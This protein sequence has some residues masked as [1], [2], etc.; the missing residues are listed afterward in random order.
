VYAAGLRGEKVVWW[1]DEGIQSILVSF[2]GSGRG[3]SEMPREV[4]SRGS[5]G[6]FWGGEFD[7]WK[8]GG[9][10]VRWKVCVWRGGGEGVWSGEK[11]SR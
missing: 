3:R 1:D 9:G 8:V 6:R 5:E 7:G 4:R 11:Y 10:I 2:L